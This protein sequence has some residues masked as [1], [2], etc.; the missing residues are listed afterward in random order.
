MP[1]ITKPQTDQRVKLSKLSIKEQLNN[2]LILYCEYS[3]LDYEKDLE[4]IVEQAIEF[5]IKK[6]KGFRLFK[7]NRKELKANSEYSLNSTGSN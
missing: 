7:K 3:K 2:E 5:V 4:S 1:I 6:D